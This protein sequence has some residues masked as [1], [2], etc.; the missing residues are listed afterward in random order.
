MFPGACFASR[1]PGTTAQN[2][3]L[4][5]AR[6]AKMMLSPATPSPMKFTTAFLDEIRAR[7]PVSEVVGR[8]VKLR[9]QGREWAGLSPFNA[10]KTPSFFVNDQKGFFHD[11]SSGKHG[12]IFTFVSE[13]EGLSFPE[14]VERLAGMAGVPMPRPTNEEAE[15]EKKRASLLDVLAMAARVFEA[16]LHASV[17]AKARGYLSDRGLG[18]AVQQR[19]SLGFSSPERFALRD[20]LAEKGV[21]VDQMIEAGL[22][23]HGEGIAVPYDRFRDRVMFPIHDRAGRVVA[24]GGR[25]MD[26]D[27]KAKYLNSPETPLFHKGALLFNHHRARKPAHDSGE[28]VV[29]EGYVDAIALSE[30][31]FPNVVAP[32]GTAL[33]AD[34]CALLWAM[35]NEPILCFDGDSAGR[36]A[37]FRAIVTALPLIG[38]G[39]SFRFAMLPQGQDPDDLVRASGPQAMAEILKGAWPFADM[40]FARESEDQRF[41]TPESRASLERRLA[42]A[43]AAIADE[44]LRRHYQADMKRRLVTLFGEERAQAGRRDGGARAPFW[45]RRA[46]QQFPPRGPRL[47]LAEQ[48]LPPQARLARKAREPAREITILAIALGHPALLETHWEEVAALDFSSA[49]LAAFRDALASA[50]PEALISPEALAEALNAAGRREERDRILAQAAKMPNWWCLRAEAAPA[51]AEHVLRQSLALHRRAGALNRELKLAERSLAAEPNEQ[52]FAR[53]LDIKSYI[54]DFAHAEAAIDGFGE[55]SGRTSSTI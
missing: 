31:G 11:F 45:Q 51:D 3:W 7:L 12:D 40:L 17:G 44:T 21:G 32:L 30:A 1:K 36:K 28:L 27:A 18:H 9:K 41:D 14:A 55:Q 2:P 20:A 39:K 52:N 23:I 22:L 49:R 34:Q 16:N 48:P 29:V 50:P 54:A 5:A 25:A 4:S 8:R 42:D 43:V 38:V 6:A 47:G 46:A 24:F 13:T 53:L 26:P 10:E 19:F 35:A 37:A 15:Q 33:T